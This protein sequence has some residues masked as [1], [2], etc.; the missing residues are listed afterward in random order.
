MARGARG[1][2]K[3]GSSR[4][5][6]NVSENG[7]EGEEVSFS[8]SVLRLIKTVGR[9]AVT[10]AFFAAILPA[11][12]LYFPGLPKWFADLAAVVAV[13]IVVGGFLWIVFGRRE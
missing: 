2:Q 9:R 8:V 12:H 10:V 13:V 4:E 6:P 11:I 7:G 1:R 5:E 3:R